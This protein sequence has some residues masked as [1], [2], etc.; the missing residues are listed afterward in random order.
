MCYRV[1]YL[2][3][4]AAKYAKYY[5]KDQKQIDHLEK[6]LEAFKIKTKAVY[7]ALAQDAVAP[8]LPVVTNEDAKEFQLYKWGLVP[9]W[10]KEYDDNLRRRF[11]VAQ[12]EEMFNKN[13]YK[14]SAAERRCLVMIDGYFDHHHRHG[15][16]F[17]YHI[18]LKNGDPMMVAGLWSRWIDRQHD[19]ELETVAVITTRGNRTMKDIHNNPEMLKR[20][21]SEDARMPVIVPPELW[22]EWLNPN[23]LADPI[24]QQKII[25]DVCV[26]YSDDL[27]ESYTCHPLN[28]G[29]DLINSEEVIRKKEYTE[30]AS[31][32][33]GLF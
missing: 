15:K 12:S 33:L 6:Q 23:T 26:P 11:V 32:Q 29:R 31:E 16:T 24:E 1:S 4:K 2:T 30:L 10:A 22:D 21:H 17:P 28:A 9:H 20:K 14:E 13:I 19:I 5:G 7:Q 8:E 27:M 3:Q 25:K 18:R